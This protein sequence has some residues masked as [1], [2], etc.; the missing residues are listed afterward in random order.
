MKRIIENNKEAIIQIPES[1]GIYF[2]YLNNKIV[3]TQMTNN[4][5]RNIMNHNRKKDIDFTSI[6]Y[7][8]TKNLNEEQLIDINNKK[9]TLFS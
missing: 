2:L 4:I 5:Q 6:T 7:C 1:F 8:C 3:H 9:I